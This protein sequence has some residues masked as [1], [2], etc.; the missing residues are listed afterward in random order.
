[1]RKEKSS[2]RLN[3]DENLH[4]NSELTAHQRIKIK[5]YFTKKRQ[6]QFVESLMLIKL[7]SASDEGKKLPDI[8]AIKRMRT[9]YK[10]SKQLFKVS[11][12]VCDVLFKRIKRGSSLGDAMFGL[13]DDTF[14]TLISASSSSNDISSAIKSATERQ[15]EIFKVE[16][17]STFKVYIG[18]ISF[19]GAG[20]LLSLVES[21]F[22]AR[23]LEAPKAFRYFEVPELK[24]QIAQIITDYSLPFVSCVLLASILNRYVLPRLSGDLR[25]YFDNYYP[26]VKLFQS[27]LAMSMFSNIALL[28]KDAGIQPR[29]A[30][31][32]L[33]EKA[34]PYEF[35]HLAKIHSNIITGQEGTDQFSTGLLPEILE[36]KLK[37]AGQGDKASIATAL[38][39]INTSGQ[40]DLVNKMKHLSTVA[41][42]IQFIFSIWLLIAG[43][44]VGITVM[45]S[46][47]A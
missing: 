8:I 37:L 14:C 43:I 28:I 9:I 34:R 32:K 27:K 47:G 36:L 30:I 10:K 33:M 4:L 25:E 6:I 23:K 20:N 44:G 16:F 13:F 3:Q 15:S 26:P 5:L 41:M 39:I 45:R 40:E 12:L 46:F 29:L 2:I 24:F 18:F 21:I 17:M 1:M 7:E 19:I 22:Q 11:D 42:L 35:D 38:N 31:D